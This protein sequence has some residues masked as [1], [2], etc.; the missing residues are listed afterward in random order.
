MQALG[1]K[2]GLHSIFPNA[3]IKYLAFPDF[4]QKFVGKSQRDSIVEFIKRKVFALY[5]L[6]KY[7]ALRNKNF[8]Y[9]KPIDLFDYNVSNA[10]ILLNEFDLIVV[11]SD[12]IL[13][14]A[15]SDD[16]KRIGLNWCPF[17]IRK[18]KRAF[19]AASASPAS[20][21]NDT[22]VLNKL[23][24]C[25]K[26]FSFIGLRDNLTIN[27]FR[28]KLGIDSQKLIKQPDPTYLLDVEKFELGA[29]YKSKIA[30]RKL[31]LYNF[32]PD[33]PF[34]KELARML[35]LKGYYVVSTSYCPL[36]DLSIDTID[37]M[38]WAGVFKL[39]DVVVTERFHD[40]VF[41]LRNCKP[42]I[43]IDWDERR[44]NEHGDS[45]TYRILEEYGLSKLH[46]NASDKNVISEVGKSIDNLPELFNQQHIQ[47]VNKAIR[48]NAEEVLKTLKN[49]I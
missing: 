34:G 29:H 43:A 36:A 49:A 22:D 4:K 33:F 30:Y 18:T 6:L 5:R 27:L 47:D 21:S 15:L 11:G 7:R 38:E 39:V 40:S 41:A 8:C 37:A 20:Y 46:F 10:N 2:K 45:K 24:E 9:T 13:E 3:E 48:H 26:G 19:F 17:D 31:A 42:V 14:K 23:V 44:Y 25:V 32:S 28:E 16:R 1:V 35:R 12:T